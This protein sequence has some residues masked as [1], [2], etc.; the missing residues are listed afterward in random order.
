MITAKQQRFVEEYLADFNGTAAAV[1]AGYSPRSSRVIAQETL[2]K[3]A[4]QAR[5]REKQGDDAN[6][7]QIT[8]EKTL[9]A[10]LDGI[11]LAR[12]NRNPAAMIEGAAQVAK[13][14]GYCAP[15]QQVKHKISAISNDYQKKLGRMSDA[16]LQA[17][18]AKAE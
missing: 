16:Q 18:I 11:E 2:L 8:R 4:V 5:I 6:R 1:R 12:L 9:Q 13:L 17:L 15:T 7:L 14:L 10:L 3:P